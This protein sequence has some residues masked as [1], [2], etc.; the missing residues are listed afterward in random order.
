MKSPD[1]IVIATVQNT[2][3]SRDDL[4]MTSA[5]CVHSDMNLDS[6]IVV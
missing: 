5:V 4:M 1:L 2:L 6:K 3:E